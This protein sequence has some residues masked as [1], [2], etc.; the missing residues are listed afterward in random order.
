MNSS[1]TS[2]STL[3]VVVPVF[4][5]EGNAAPLVAGITAAVRPLDI[6]FELIV[7]DDGSSDRT[8][9]VLRDLIAE[10]PE[11]VVV[12]LRRNFGQA[13]ALQ[14]GF[15]RARGGVIV[16]LDGDLQN[17][18]KDIP[19]LLERIDAGADVVSGWRVNRQ[20]AMVLRKV[21][22]W[23]ANRLIRWVTGVPIH[24]QGCS[25]KAYRRE[26]VERLDL[27]SDLHRFITILTMP[28]G[29]AIEEIE[30]RH[31][32][33]ISGE[34]KYGLSRVLKVLVDLTAIQMLTRFRESPTRWF[35]L[36]GI[37]FLLG[38]IATG[39]A[40][41]GAVDRF[42]VLPTVSLLLALIFVSCLFAALLGEA[43]IDT[44]GRAERNRIVVREWKGTQ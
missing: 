11:L 40:S 9:D 29:A 38:S 37:P 21:P 25:L 10:T 33:R 27:Y 3:S 34:S 1:E 7:V 36:L 28:Q 13:S 22:S 17:D 35:G 6:P 5:E 16:T 23:I 32:P 39:V 19:R 44:L 31:H 41:I 18:P 24:D 26:V 12:R 20:D 2:A 8:S 42:V 15:D 14:A 43:I 30:V 4:N